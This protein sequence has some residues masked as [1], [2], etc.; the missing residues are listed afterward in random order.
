[1]ARKRATP[2]TDEVAALPP[3]APRRRRE[4]KIRRHKSASISSGPLIEQGGGTSQQIPVE[5]IQK[6]QHEIVAPPLGDRSFED[7]AKLL[8]DSTDYAS[9]VYQIATDTAGLGWHLDPVDQDTEMADAEIDVAT[10]FF[11][12]PN[13]YATIGQLVKCAIIDYLVLGNAWIE[14]LRQN[15]EPGGLPSGMVHAPGIAMRLRSNL[16]GFVMLGKDQ[17]MHRFFRALFSDPAEPSSL[18]PQTGVVLNEM[19]YFRN[20]HPASPW[21][22]VPK[23][24]PAMRAIKGT[25][26]SIDRNIRYFTNRA[27]PEY[28]ITLEGQTD[29]VPDKELEALEEDIKE[30]F[31]NLIKGDDYK[32]F[33]ST[34]P[35]GI[36]LKLERLAAP[37]DDETLRQYRIDNRDEIVRSQGMMP[38]RIGIIES[39]NLGGGTGESQIEIYKT[40][41]VKPLQEMVERA[42]NAILHSDRPLGFGLK[43]VQF[44][45]DEIDSIDEA[46]EAQITNTIGSIG[47]LTI[48]ELRAYAT[49]FLKLHLDPLDEPWADLPIQLVVPQL[50]EF[51]PPLDSSLQQEAGITPGITPLGT[52]AIA[53]Q[54]RSI[55]QP[56]VAVDKAYRRFRARQ[57]AEAAKVAAV[58]L[59]TNGS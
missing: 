19:I 53:P 35:T 30:H 42:F 34:L 33:F 39:G 28:V 3:A 11:Q 20:Y 45:F 59:A 51:F 49:Q 18:D 9:C 43:T 46:R 29:N 55:V 2:V 38:N 14:V 41:T 31:R 52:P 40:S 44:K 8:L 50:A 16:H 10:I 54:V 17:A 36:T 47:A 27:F 12:N 6:M 1:M 15:N 21:Y 22:G 32:T 58:P 48:N 4:P 7:F 13:P 26:M 56:T 25:T 57:E 23:I 5:V 24:V 37:F